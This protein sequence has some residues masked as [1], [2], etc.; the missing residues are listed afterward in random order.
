MAR[1]RMLSAAAAAAAVFFGFTFW[2]LG[3]FAHGQTLKVIDDVVLVAVSVVAFVSAV[4]AARVSRGRL[5]NAWTALALGL[6][7]WTVG[8][9]LW[10]YQ[11]IILGQIAFPSIADAFFLIFPVGAG[12]AL[13]LFRSRRSDWSDIRVVLDGLIVAGSLFVVSW[14]LVMS[15]VYE[16]GAATNFEFVLL[17]AYPVSDL[18]LLTIATMVLVGS[19]S[20][21]RVPITLITLGLAAMALADSG[22]AYLATQEEY[23]SGDVVDIGWVAGLLL[24]ALAATGGQRTLADEQI[25]DDRPGLASVWLPY[26]PLLLAGLTVLTAPPVSRTSGPVIVVAVLLAVTVLARQF[27]A[28]QENRTLIAAVADQAL[29]DPLTRLP[30]RAL[31]QDRLTHAMQLRRRYGTSVGVMVLDLNDFKLVNDTLGHPAGDELLNRVG[32]RI[33]GSVWNGETVARLGGDEF[34][35]MVEGDADQSGVVARQ[36][37]SAFDQPM[38]IDGRQMMVRPSAGLAVAGAGDDVSAED[39]LKRADL[40]MYT[41]KRSQTGEVLVFS[42]DLQFAGLLGGGPA[43]DHLLSELRSAIEDSALALVYQPKVDLRTGAIV[44]VE[45]LLRW[46]HPQ[47]GPIGPDEFLP[48]VRRNGLI[49]PV[50][51][52]VVNRALDD[53][54]CWRAAGISVPVAVNL[55]APTLAELSLPDRIERALSVRGLDGSA[56]TV[57]ITEDLFPNNIERMGSVVRELRARGIQVAIDDFGSGYSALWCL[58]EL[59]VGEVKL[60]RSLVAPITSDPRAAA[61]VRTVTELARVL[62]LTTVA[63]GV[64]DAATVER[65]R[66]FG[67]DVGQGY[68]FSVPVT[69]DQVLELV[70]LNASPMPAG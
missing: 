12:V 11:E 19:R 69:A 50:S 47:R 34:A 53:A 16:A 63:E 64:E 1:T 46:T 26:L 18:V 70:R 25:I 60:D 49:G 15:R 58:R 3:G 6:L 13:L 68:Y 31:F 24:L 43:E 40:A 2:L 45:A 59:P 21:Q 52:F 23:S 35:V 57:E 65:L 10:A 8:E 4:F 37:M 54:Q 41:A 48:L 14:L 44:G 55:F 29:R 27:F 7:A 38:I 42:P 5:R 56:L 51:E 36:I 32:E 66:E 9:I 28:V 62:G 33:A 67:C 39:L 20:E 61:V 22:Y 17:L 30:N